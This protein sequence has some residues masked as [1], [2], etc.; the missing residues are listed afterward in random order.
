L[1][2]DR[3]ELLSEVGHHLRAH[4]D[5]HSGNGR[6]ELA[7]LGG[8]RRVSGGKSVDV[9]AGVG[10]ELP[11]PLQLLEVADGQFEDVG[12]LQSGD[13]LALGLEG[14]DHEVAEV[15]EALVDAGPTLLFDEGLHHLAVLEA[16]GHF[17]IHFELERSFFCV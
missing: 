17:Q 8:A 2:A 3:A 12:L 10:L 7:D 9:E 13:G 5:L 16:A 1:A 14:E 6:Q 15:V 4:A 11:L